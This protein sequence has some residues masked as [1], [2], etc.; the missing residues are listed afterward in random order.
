MFMRETLFLGTETLIFLYNLLAKTVIVI[1]LSSF[2]LRKNF[3][4]LL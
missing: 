3:I 2:Y 4:M 1:T